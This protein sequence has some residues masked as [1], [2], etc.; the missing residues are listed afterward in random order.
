MANI[1]YPTTTHFT[2]GRFEFGLRANVQLVTSNHNGSTQSIEMPGSRWLANL[3]WDGVQDAA[4]YAEIESFWATVRGQ[5]NRVLLY[6]IRRPVP[7]GTLQTNGTFSASAAVGAPSLNLNATTGL[8]LLAGDMVGW[9][10]GTSYQLFMATAT[11]TSSAGVMTVQV[12]PQVRKAI[13][14]GQNYTVIRPTAQ[15]VLTS[16]EV[17]IPYSG[18]VGEGFSVDLV[19]AYL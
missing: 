14:S 8:T 2:P 19:E 1:S 6:H 9:N 17:R 11:A 16:N 18:Y 13:T 7:Q 4:L 10:D 3:H 15:F 12:T 5:A